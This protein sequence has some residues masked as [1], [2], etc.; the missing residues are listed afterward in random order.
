M[1]LEIGDKVEKIGKLAF[2]GCSALSS[3]EIGA[4]VTT[5]ETQAFYNCDSL[6]N[7]VIGNDVTEVG[8]YAFYNCKELTNIYYK[9]EVGE[10]GEISFGMYNTDLIDAKRYY[11]SENEPEQEG[12][13]WYYDKKGE[14]VVW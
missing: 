12:D 13:Y 1:K 11:Y 6:T 4:K 3:V 8:N 7:I 5:I 9:G 10:W 14:V 2:D